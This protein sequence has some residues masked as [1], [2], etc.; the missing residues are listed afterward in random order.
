MSGTP[1]AVAVEDLHKDFAGLEVLKGVSMT[2]NEGEVI[3]I[4]GSSG[5][6]KS[7]FLRCINLLELPSRGRISVSGEE[8]R[9]RRHACLH[10]FRRNRD[11]TGSPSSGESH[12]EDALETEWNPGAVR[13]LRRGV[14]HESGQVGE[15]RDSPTG[16]ARRLERSCQRTGV[17]WNAFARDSEPFFRVSIF[18]TT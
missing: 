14:R 1:P 11:S 5:S 10:T 18:G 13:R 17:R 3:S 16:G 4:I 2:A 12:R 6:G 7:T 9:L 8:V 15:R